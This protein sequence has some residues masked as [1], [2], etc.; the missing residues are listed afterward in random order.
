HTGRR[1]PVLFEPKTI[2]DGIVKPVPTMQLKELVG[3]L[4]QYTK[5]LDESLNFYD[6][7]Y[8][9]KYGRNLSV[10]MVAG[11]L[12]GEFFH[13]PHVLSVLK[14]HPKAVYTTLKNLERTMN[15]VLHK[16]ILIEELE[17]GTH[18][19]RYLQQL[20]NKAHDH[21][22]GIEE[23]ISIYGDLNKELER[24]VGA[25]LG[26][27]LRNKHNDITV[28]KP[29]WEIPTINLSA[30]FHYGHVSSMIEAAK[31]VAPLIAKKF[32]E[33]DI[34]VTQ[35]PEGPTTNI[36]VETQKR[37]QELLS[38]DFPNYFFTGEEGEQKNI[39][40]EEG[41]R[42]WI[43][44]PIDGTTNAINNNKD[45]CLSIAN[46]L[47]TGGEWVT[48]DGCICLPA[49]GE[50]FWAEK[51]DGAYFID[52]EENENELK[53]VEVNQLAGNTVDLSI[54]G[55]GVE[56]GPELIKKLWSE[57]VKWRSTGSAGYTLAKVAGKGNA[58]AIVTANDY[59][60]A[61]GLLIAQEAG[62]TVST[63]NFERETNQG[64]REF[65]AYIATQGKQIHEDLTSIIKEVLKI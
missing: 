51:N 52:R 34:K 58:G 13:T 42:R 41:I 1:I 10:G 50:I 39:K 21:P 19:A 40:L 6:W 60:V 44:D 17:I 36:D 49:H 53:I 48:T 65:T 14:D 11:Y 62:A 15:E 63:I 46:Q 54:R 56:L 33:R 30:G 27:Y 8:D 31:E 61:A 22:G 16:K 4:N 35:K 18:E 43:V 24:Y 28:L 32:S 2:P 37:L 55:F 45:F 7:L 20:I 57:N 38:K 25:L 3:S 23:W 12:V 26:D 59:D 5:L 47:F 64:R 9:P 29:I